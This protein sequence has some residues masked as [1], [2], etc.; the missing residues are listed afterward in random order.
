[1]GIITVAALLQ[2]TVWMLHAYL[3]AYAAPNRAWRFY[4]AGHSLVGA[5]G[6]AAL[7]VVGAVNDHENLRAHLDAATTFFVA[8]L[9]W[10][11]GY[12]VQM[13]AHPAATSPASLRLKC[14][15][16]VAAAAALV[17]F[18]T[19]AG[20]GLMAHYREIAAGEWIFAV[21]CMVSVWSLSAEFGGGEPAGGGA[22]S[23]TGASA[24]GNTGTG[25]RGGGN[26]KP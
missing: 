4:T 18:F 14:T 1:M 25:A 9:V 23:G 26:P 20:E 10:Q 5:V 8:L 12:T 11:L 3:C 21:A 24:G 15:A 16:A 6:S 7:A 22:G 19:L 2:L 13:A 17:V